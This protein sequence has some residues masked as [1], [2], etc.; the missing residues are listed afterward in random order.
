M[1]ACII[2]FTIVF[3]SS[4]KIENL[5]GGGCRAKWAVIVFVSLPTFDS[6]GLCGRWSPT[7]AVEKVKAV[8]LFPC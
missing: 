3:G 5:S 6:P 7:G 1:Q 8:G 4:W 2:P